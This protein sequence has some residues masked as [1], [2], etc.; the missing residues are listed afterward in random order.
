M[1]CEWPDSYGA[2]RLPRR[3]ADGLPPNP[4]L[5]RTRA[6]RSL[7]SAPGASSPSVAPGRAPVSRKPLRVTAN[8]RDFSGPPWWIAGAF[9]VVVLALIVWFPIYYWRKDR[10]R[11]KAAG[12][13][14]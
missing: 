1:N 10:A 3:L 2:L 8:E 13:E 9:M 4:R 6:A 11:R 12:T 14:R 7:R 5:H